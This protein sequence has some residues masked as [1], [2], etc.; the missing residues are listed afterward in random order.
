MTQLKHA[1]SALITAI[2]VFFASILVALPAHADTLISDKDSVQRAA[3]WI[4]D[5]WTSGRYS[6]SDTGLVAD[7]VMALASAGLYEST[8]N[9]MVAQLRKDGPSW[10]DGRGDALAKVLIAA[11]MSGHADPAHF[12]DAKRDLAAELVGQVKGKKLGQAWGGYLATIALARLDKL[13]ALSSEDLAYLMS[14]MTTSQDG[15]FGW[16]A[17]SGDPDYTGLGIS[18]ML[19]LTRSNAPAAIKSQAQARLGDAIAWTVSEANRQRDAQNDYF[20]ATYSSASSTGM[21][22]SALAEAGVNTESPRRALKRE[23][24]AT[25]SHAAWSY[26]HMGTENDLRATTQAIF[27]VTGKGY[28]TGGYHRFAKTAT[29]TISGTAKVGKKLTAKTGTWSPT[30]AFSYQWYRNGKAIS[31][32]TSSTYTLTSSDKGTTITVKVT[33]KKAGYVTVAKTSKKTATVKAGTFTTKTPTISGTA[34]VGKKLTAKTGTW[35]PKPSFSYQWYRNGSKIKG[36]TKSTYTLKK[37]DRRKK[38]TVKVT[39]KKSGYTTASK[40]SKATSTV[41]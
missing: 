7:G 13:G 20:W 3:K 19:L 21:V 1:S 37:S 6:K 5:E 28:A 40:T 2:A 18:A 15:G 30:A 36:A 17:S 11:D 33:G 25:T 22:A 9:Q 16:N 34:K 27:G 12:F 24:A 4:S 32:A 23:Q 38:I 8:M 29:P 41:K 26:E 35:S 39:G 10:S 14:R 31:K